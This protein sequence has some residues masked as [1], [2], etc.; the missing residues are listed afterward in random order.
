M[1]STRV[2]IPELASAD[3]AKATG[4]TELLMRIEVLLKAFWK[5]IKMNLVIVFWIRQQKKANVYD[6]GKLG[7]KR[8]WV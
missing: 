7:R 5:L 1:H 6:A 3:I 4:N 2:M 8:L